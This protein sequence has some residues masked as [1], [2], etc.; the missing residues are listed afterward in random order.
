MKKLPLLILS[1]WSSIVL[2]GQAPKFSND[3]LNVGVGARG[4]A[5]G[6]AVSSSSFSINSGYWN[7]AGLVH[8]PVNFQVGAQHAEWFAGIGNYDYVAFGKKLDS[9]GRSFGSLSLIRMGI[10]DIPNTLRLRAPD[11]SIDYDRLSTFSVADYA[12]LVSYGRKL[13]DGPWALG[14]NAKVIHRAFGTFA[15]AWGF[16]IDAGILYRRDRLSFSLMG[17]DITTTFNAYK[18]SFSDDEKATLLLTGNDVP[19]SSV[20]YTLPKLITGFAYNW[21]LSNNVGLTTAL[22]IEF[23]TNGTLAALISSDKFVADP[24]LGFEL[25]FKQK[26]YIRF[27]ASNFQTILSDESPG[28]EEFSVQPSGGLG[29]KFGKIGLDYALTNIGNTGAGLYSHYFSL[30]LDF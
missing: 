29:L 16:G 1:L 19:V 13:K 25:D 10:D 22:D 20:E 8:V 27:G 24:K 3:F 23:S 28:K 4:M 5:M 15:S 6:G 11:G 18:F 12:L 26:V 17:R 7:P 21:R 9:E 30:N 2:F 14:L